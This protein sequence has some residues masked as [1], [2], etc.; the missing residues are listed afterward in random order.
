MQKKKSRSATTS[1]KS[2]QSTPVKRQIE[3]TPGSVGGERGKNEA[4]CNGGDS[5]VF[6]RKG[7]S[8]KRLILDSNEEEEEEEETVGESPQRENGA[9]GVK[10]CVENRVHSGEDVVMDTATED[11]TPT[12]DESTISNG[13]ISIT[14]SGC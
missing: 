4:A 3:V 13:T 1:N 10:D 8:R 5:P 6:K 14:L 7:K 12:G 9:Q 2:K 11:R